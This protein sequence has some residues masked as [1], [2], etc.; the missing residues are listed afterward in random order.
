MKKND[1]I[2]IGH[3]LEALI[4]KRGYKTNMEFTIDYGVK[5]ASF[6]RY[7][8]GLKQG[9]RGGYL[10]TLVKYLEFLDSSLFEL[11][12]FFGNIDNQKGNNF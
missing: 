3:A 7:I 5:Y 1:Y 8:S 11:L 12:N 9:R 2:N 10:E 6:S 4:R